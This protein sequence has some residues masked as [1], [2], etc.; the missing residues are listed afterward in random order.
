MSLESVILSRCGWLAL[1][2]TGVGEVAGGLAS[3]QSQGQ[4]AEGMASTLIHLLS[5]LGPGPPT[6]KGC[7][8]HAPSPTF[9]GLTGYRP[10]L[11]R[12][13]RQQGLEASSVVAEG[14]ASETDCP[15]Q[16]QPR[17]LFDPGQII[18]LL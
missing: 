5:R 1:A 2:L 6:D 13:G 9:W 3:P 18:C 17:R 15:D 8:C 14:A 16:N 4:E 11:P 12:G 10:L 7:T